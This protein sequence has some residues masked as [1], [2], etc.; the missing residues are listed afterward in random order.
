MAGGKADTRSQSPHSGRYA[1]PAMPGQYRTG[2][3]NLFA[4]S[5][6]ISSSLL[7]PGRFAHSVPAAGHR[8]TSI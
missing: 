8:R 5:W 2:C 3:A 7:F 1:P 4:G 6:A